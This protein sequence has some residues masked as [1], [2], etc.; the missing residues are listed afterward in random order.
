[1][2]HRSAPVIRG[3]QFA[4]RIVGLVE[5][6]AERSTYRDAA[7]DADRTERIEPV[8]VLYDFCLDG[9]RFDAGGIAVRLDRMADLR[10]AGGRI[11]GF[12]K[13]AQR[14]IRSEPRGLVALRESLAT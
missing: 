8:R 12:L 5:R 6:S 14:M 7:R 3:T 2:V 9:L 4:E 11:A 1:M 10:Q 13:V